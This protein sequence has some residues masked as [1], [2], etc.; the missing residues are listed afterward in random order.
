MD[1]SLNI[2]VLL[3]GD[4]SVGKTTFL[5]KYMNNQYKNNYELTIGV[6]YASKI[7]KI[8]DKNINLQIWD[9][10]GQESFRAITTSYFRSA[11]CALIFFDVSNI[12]SYNN[13]EYWV[14]T[15]LSMSNNSENSILLV[16]NKSDN[17]M[18]DVS[19]NDCLDLAN[20]LNVLYS[21]I[22]VKNNTIDKLNDIILT[23]LNNI[24]LKQQQYL[25]P[26]N[27][28]QPI[29]YRLLCGIKKCV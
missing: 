14:N 1:T 24:D 22:S 25:K 28:K 6:D 7:I 9:T 17:I 10:A 27:I 18:R 19:K 16:G 5:K 29:K 2:K 15:Y 8:D 12:D 11:N 20:S 23:L 3:L 26:I 13:I 4:P 21:E